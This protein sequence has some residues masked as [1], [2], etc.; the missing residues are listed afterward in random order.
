MKV[1]VVCPYDLGVPGGVQ[2]LTLELVDRL[3][4]I[5]HHAWLVG[6]GEHPAARTVGNTLR[7]RA[8]KS[9]VPIAFGPG[10]GRRTREAVGDADVVHV[11]EPFIPRVSTAALHSGRPVV[12]TFHA[13]APAWASALY[14]LG[15]VARLPRG[16]VV[17]AVSPVAAAHLPGRWGPIEVIPNAIDVGMYRSAGSG[18]PRRVV[19]LGRDDPRKGLDLLL[20]AWPR[21]HS[22]F[23]DSELVVVGAVRDRQVAGVRFAGRVSEAAKRSELGGAGV[24]VAPNTGGESF[25]IVV[26]E[27]MASGCAIVASDLPAFRAVAGE[28]GL[29]VPPGDVDALTA[30][31]QSLLADPERVGD[32][33]E[34][35]RAQVR[36]FD[37]SVVIE[38]Y[39]AMYQRAG[40]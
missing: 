27:A 40:S 34:R 3:V 22:A 18:H 1:A 31:L 26:A 39:E 23:G 8:N 2:Q 19:F 11:H 12:A 38:Q 5:G 15:V 10:V 4:A 16:A 20:A 35:A 17:T 32:L 24:F 36:R 37:W 25:G 9:V 28:S 7:V 21:V 13:D 29:F 30:T 14:R 6:P 33:G